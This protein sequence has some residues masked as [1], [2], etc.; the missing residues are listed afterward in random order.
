[1]HKSTLF[2]LMLA[3]GLSLTA[4]AAELNPNAPAK[5]PMPTAD[6]V[7]RGTQNDL[8]APHDLVSRQHFTA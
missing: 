6:Q 8:I 7:G 4:Y 5:L 2:N 3:L 1:M